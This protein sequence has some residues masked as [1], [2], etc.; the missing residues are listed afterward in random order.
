MPKLVSEPYFDPDLERLDSRRNLRT[1]NANDDSMNTE[2]K[3]VTPNK[4]SASRNNLDPSSSAGSIQTQ[5]LGS[6][7]KFKNSKLF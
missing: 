3:Q 4:I 5:N 7:A 6:V 2:L 1:E